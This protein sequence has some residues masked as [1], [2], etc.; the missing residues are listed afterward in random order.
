MPV[1]TVREAIRTVVKQSEIELGSCPIDTKRLVM[2]GDKAAIV[3][4]AVGD[5]LDNDEKK[6]LERFKKSFTLCGGAESVIAGALALPRETALR[7]VRR[8]ERAQSDGPKIVVY[9]AEWC[10]WCHKAQ[11]WLKNQGLAFEYRDTDDPK[12]AEA[13]AAERQKRGETEGGIPYILIGDKAFLGFDEAGIKRELERKG[14]VP[15]GGR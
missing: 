6:E 4:R 7:A 8:V 12:N 2:N 9:G 14:A 13:L 15:T 11:E 3:A 1:E 5:T 10:G